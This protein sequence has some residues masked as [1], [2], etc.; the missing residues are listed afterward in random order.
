MAIKANL[1]VDQG[2]TFVTT[3]NL[4]DADDIPLDLTSYTGSSQIRKHYTSSNSTS[5]TVATGGTTGVLTLSLTA[6]ATANL[7]AGRY[8][9]DVEIADSSNNITRVVEGIVTVTPNITR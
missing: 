5:F 3:L 9:Y 8:M 4:T 7:T 6:N 2:S 1:I